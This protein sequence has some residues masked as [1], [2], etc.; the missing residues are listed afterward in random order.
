MK[1]FSVGLAGFLA[2]VVLFGVAGNLLLRDG[3]VG[4]GVTLLL[5]VILG[6][7]IFHARRDRLLTGQGARI[8]IGAAALFGLLYSWRDVTPVSLL[9]L[10][11]IGVSIVLTAASRLGRDP[12]DAYLWDYVLDAFNFGISSI[13]LPFTLAFT[14][15][16]AMKSTNRPASA[17]GFAVLRGMLVAAPILV[18]FGA[19]LVSA[20]A[21]VEQILFRAFDFDVEYAASH[22][23]VFGVC[24]WGAATIWWQCLEG[25]AGNP[26]SGSGLRKALTWGAI[27]INVVLGLVTALFASFIAIQARYFFGGHE[28]VLT[29]A[30][31]TYADYARSGFFELATVAGIA[32]AL[33]VVCSQ[34][35]EPAAPSRRRAFKVLSAVFIVS[36]LVILA[37]AFHRLSLYIDAF[38]MP[39][40]RVYAAAFMVC[41]GAIF[42]WLYVCVHFDHARQF[43]WGC[44]LFGYAA[45]FALL[46][47]N[48]DAMVARI[49]MQRAIEGK[50]LDLDYMRT[51]SLDA[52]PPVVRALPRLGEAEQQ[53]VRDFLDVHAADAAD[54]SARTWT[55]GMSRASYALESLDE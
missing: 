17:T 37:S 34:F 50:S 51:L 5:A 10:A 6:V 42:L 24:A 35:I 39:R 48:P 49:N 4:I 44:V 23:I 9:V 22:F 7:V 19:L 46:A 52:I 18:I 43:A 12:R 45:T 11:V 32:L 36:V 38:G 53:R 29:K 28:R 1:H 8:T 13:R 2:A 16:D 26:V 27:E 41:T 20:D 3:P 25:A 14:A 15:Q 30:G 31:L 47:A 55:L 33:L 21:I 40:A 54:R